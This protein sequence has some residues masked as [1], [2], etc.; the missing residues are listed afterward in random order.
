MIPLC[1][2]GCGE[3][4]NIIS[5][6]DNSRGRIKGQYYKYV[7]GHNVGKGENA[8]TWRGGIAIKNGYLSVFIPDHARADKDGYIAKHIILAEKA[9]GKP[10][11]L[12]AEVHH[13][14]GT[15]NSGPLVL[16]Q[17]RKYHMLLHQRMRALKACGN[18]SWL[19][20]WICKEYD[21]PGKLYLPE[22]ASPRHP[23][24]MKE[25]CNGR[26]GPSGRD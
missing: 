5:K 8:P 3:Q 17:D 1:A 10:L 26:S 15:K 20:C 16:C 23:D 18:A 12:K 14:N 9:L 2:C 6:T 25:Y 4:T 19:K 22:K 21:D 11:P 7:W 24:C 13:Y